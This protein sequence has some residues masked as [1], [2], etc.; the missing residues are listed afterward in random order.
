MVSFSIYLLDLL[1]VQGTLNSLL[2][3]HS[4]KASILQCSAFFIVQLSHPYRTTGK[5]IAL[6]RWIFVGKT[7]PLHFIMLSRLIMAFLPRRMHL[8]IIWLQS[9]SAVILEPP[10]IKSLIVSIISLSICHELIG[11]VALI[12]VFWMLSF[13]STF[14][15]STFTFIKRLFSFSLLSAIRPSAYLR[16]LIF[17]LAILIPHCALSSLAFLMMYSA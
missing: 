3:H 11:P 14:S 10:K 15:L 5:T 8:L 17:L 12:L 13:K 2:Q 6:T 16:L 7:M 1:A 4:S 9:P